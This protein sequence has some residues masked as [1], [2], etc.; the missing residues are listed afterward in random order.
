MKRFYLI[1]VF[2]IISVSLFSQYDYLGNNGP[3]CSSSMTISY[4]Y[5]EYKKGNHGHGYKIFRDG[6]EVRHQFGTW[7]GYYVRSLDFL[8]DSVGF[9]TEYHQ[10]VYY[11]YRTIDYGNNWEKI[12]VKNMELYDIYFV[13][14]HTAY[15]IGRKYG[16]P[17]NVTIERL[18]KGNQRTV[19]SIDS[20]NN[21]TTYYSDKDTIKGKPL[22]K[23][24]H[25]LIFHIYKSNVNISF[26]II[27]G[28]IL[29]GV[30]SISNSTSI[31]IFPNPA[32]DKF[33]LDIDKPRMIDIAIYDY[34][35]KLI[36]RERIDDKTVNIS[37]LTPGVYLLLTNIEG[38]IRK[39][40]FVVE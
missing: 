5:S 11:I 24:Q 19:F 29:S 8:N 39:A 35:G 25:N 16:M 12:G 27:F 3:D 28:H 26:D 13:N 36:K 23:N 22:C 4:T 21:T 15:M 2:S 6:V 14:Q 18:I 20:L 32:D 17:N 33:F 9:V 10:G 38:T 31:S 40:K 1:F 34:T 37:E 30:N 7:G